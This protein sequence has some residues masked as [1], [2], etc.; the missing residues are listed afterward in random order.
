MGPS[1]AEQAAKDGIVDDF[2]ELYLGDLIG[3]LA[4]KHD[5]SSIEMKRLNTTLAA[6]KQQAPFALL[7]VFLHYTRALCLLCFADYVR[8]GML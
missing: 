6:L 1:K 8:S 7:R 3:R 4:E 2:E 5:L